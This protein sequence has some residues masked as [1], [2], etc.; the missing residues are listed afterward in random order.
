MSATNIAASPDA[1]MVLP[2]HESLPARVEVVYRPSRERLTRALLTLLGFWLLA[3]IAFIIPPH[4]PWS[5]IALV[6]GIYFGFKQWRGEYVLRSFS[7]ECPRCR[8]NLQIEPGTK[9]RLPHRLDC[10]NCHHEPWLE[11]TP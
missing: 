5:L 3:P 8:S 6:C 1:R 2:G 4:V 7:G 11:L 9:I 10:F